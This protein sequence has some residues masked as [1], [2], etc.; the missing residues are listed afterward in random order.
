MVSAF[1]KSFF[2]IVMFPDHNRKKRRMCYTLKEYS[3]KG[4]DGV[5]FQAPLIYRSGNSGVVYVV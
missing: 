1:R 4:K 2:R 5:V 3:V